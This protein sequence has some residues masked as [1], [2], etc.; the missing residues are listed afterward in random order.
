MLFPAPGGICCSACLGLWYLSLQ[1]G[2]P[3]ALCHPA[4]CPTA[5]TGLQTPGPGM[6]LPLVRTCSYHMPGM[7]STLS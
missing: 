4:L 7:T 3:A 1:P 5:E 2:A 6:R